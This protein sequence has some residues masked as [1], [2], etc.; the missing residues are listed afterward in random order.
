MGF[1]L[2]DTPQSRWKDS[3]ASSPEVKLTLRANG[4]EVTQVITPTLGMIPAGFDAPDTDPTASASAG[5]SLESDQYYA[6]RYVYASSQYPYV[7]NDISGGGELWP[8]S[9]PSGYVVEQAA[10]ADNTITVTVTKTTRSDVDWIWVYRTQPFATQEEAEN[11]AAAGLMYYLTRVGNDNTAGTTTVSDNGSIT[12]ATIEILEADN[13]PAP[14]AQFCVYDGVHWWLWGNWEFVEEVTLDGTNAV[15]LNSGSWFSGRDGQIARFDGITSGGFDN[16]GSFYFNADSATVGSLYSDQDLTG[17]LAVLASGTTR[18]HIKGPSTTLY[19]SKKNNPF[20]WGFTQQDFSSGST[21]V[22]IP[23]MWFLPVGGGYGSAIA[24]LPNERLLKLDT[25]QPAISFTLDLNTTES[26]DEMEGTKQIVDGTYSVGSHFSQFKASQ[27]DGP[28]LMGV[29]A[30][31]FSIIFC[32]GQDQVPASDR[33]FATLREIIHGDEEQ[34]FWHGVHDSETEMNCWWIKTKELD[35]NKCDTLVFQHA[36]T[37]EWGLMFDP[38]I[39]ASATIYDPVEDRTFTMVGSEQGHVGRAFDTATFTHWL[40]AGTSGVVLTDGA[41]YN[42]TAVVAECVADNGGSLNGAG[43]SVT[44]PNSESVAFIIN[45]NNTGVGGIGDTATVSSVNTGTEVITTATDH[46]FTTADAVFNSTSN[47]VP[48]SSPSIEEFT[49]PFYVRSLS[50][51]TIA[52]Y[53]TAADANAD[54]NRVNFTTGAWAG[55]WK[56]SKI[57]AWATAL[58]YQRQVFQSDDDDVPIIPTNSTAAAIA[59]AFANLGDEAFSTYTLKLRVDVAFADQIVLYVLDGANVENLTGTEVNSGFNIEMTTSMIDFGATIEVPSGR[60]E[61]WSVIHN[62]SGEPLAAFRNDASDGRYVFISLWLPE[63]D[64]EATTTAPAITEESIAFFGC[65]PCRAR[66]YVNAN[67]PTKNKKP[68]E[69]WTTALNVNDEGPQWFMAWF[70]E[71]DDEPSAR[72]TL[73]RDTIPGSTLPDSASW[74]NKTQIP[75]TLLNQFGL[76]FSEYGFEAFQLLNVTLK[77]NVSS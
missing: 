10:G 38:E 21:T 22:R 44:L 51:T 55:T 54:T 9:N 77:F 45:I 23:Q 42:K 4:E 30:K 24:V 71:F 52:L 20:S 56:I 66:L 11:A 72:F 57:P 35:G 2:T 41:S 60:T 50:A 27:T 26:P 47:T 33:V 16:R 37:G 70:K 39:S 19:R 14:T 73:N 18:I 75:S 8:R 46:P 58:D 15:T 1:I 43:F 3:F 59:Q 62:G 25:E 74:L 53:P 32:D 67:S 13:F 29:D 69:C 40:T 5:G 49:Q 6:Y 64:T 48:A 61:Y 28:V 34:R 31:N 36:P 17:T 65:I 76:E 12:P 68:E 63:G 7:Q